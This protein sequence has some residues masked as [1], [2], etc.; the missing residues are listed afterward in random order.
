M[1]AIKRASKK[2]ARPRSQ[3]RLVRDCQCEYQKQQPWG[4]EIQKWVG[5]TR[6][7]QYDTSVPTTAIAL[8]ATEKMTYDLIRCRGCGKEIVRDVPNEKLSD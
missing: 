1:K 2:T 8:M 7:W 4:Y 6:S 3:Q 5:G